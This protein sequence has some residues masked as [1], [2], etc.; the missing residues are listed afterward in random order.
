MVVDILQLYR[1]TP[2]LEWSIDEIATKEI[3]EGKILY[4][5]PEEYSETKHWHTEMKK[6]A[7]GDYPYAAYDRALMQ[8]EESI[9]S[10]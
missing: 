3:P 9:C 7:S 8:L 2:K 4:N 6:V 1:D 5:T 10:K